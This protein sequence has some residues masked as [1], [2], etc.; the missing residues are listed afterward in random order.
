MATSGQD[1]NEIRE[2]TIITS[3]KRKTSQDIRDFIDAKVRKHTERLE[4]YSFIQA[5]WNLVHFS[6]PPDPNFV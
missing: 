4:Y 3:Q 5:D 1:H 6:H 2:F